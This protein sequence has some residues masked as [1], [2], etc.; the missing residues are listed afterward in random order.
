MP[1]SLGKHAVYS[2]VVIGL[3]VSL[4]VK[5]RLFV[6]VQESSECWHQRRL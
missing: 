2:Q 5:K 1:L 4:G 6:Y 3:L